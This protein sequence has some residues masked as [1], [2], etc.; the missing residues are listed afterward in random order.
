MLYVKWLI[1][2]LSEKLMDLINLPTAPIVVLFANQ[3]GWL[4]HCLRW[5]QTP[6]NS[7]D[8]DEPWQLER[9]PFKRNTGIRRYLN[10]VAWLYRNSMYGYANEV[11]GFPK[12]DDYYLFT[13]FGDGLDKPD[14]YDENGGAPLRWWVEDIDGNKL[15]FQWFW[16]YRYGDR[17][18]RINIGWKLWDW[19]NPVWRRCNCVMSINPWKKI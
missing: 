15:A 19:H 2:A 1:Y 13:N 5:W 16:V 12:R 14:G 9:R 18:I 4:P 11:V 3:D 8:G 7:L 10:R 6:D 17:R